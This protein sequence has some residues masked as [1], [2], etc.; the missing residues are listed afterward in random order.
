M[1][2]GVTLRDAILLP[3]SYIYILALLLLLPCVGFI[4]YCLIQLCV[5]CYFPGNS[6]TSYFHI[7]L[8]CLAQGVICFELVIFPV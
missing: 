4:S 6:G 8:F 2:C 5:E 7:Y 1:C 3:R